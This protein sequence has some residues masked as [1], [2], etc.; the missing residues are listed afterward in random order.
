MSLQSND[1][2]LDKSKY[3]K[4]KPLFPIYAALSGPHLKFVQRSLSK[5]KEVGRFV[6][7][8]YHQHTG[9]M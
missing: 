6:Q 2:H 4:C 3:V 1:S 5:V 7:H 8:R 9:Q